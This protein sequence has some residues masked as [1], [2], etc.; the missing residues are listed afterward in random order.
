[1]HD[2][3]DHQI[4]TSPKSV[5]SNAWVAR[6][7]PLLAVLPNPSRCN[8]LVKLYFDKVEWIHH[9]I[10]V[11]SFYAWFRQFWTTGLTS[12]HCVQQLAL[13]FA[14]L[15]L[16]VHFDL[17]LEHSDRASLSLSD[18]LDAEDQCFY[19]ASYDALVASAYLGHHSLTVLQTL[20]LQGLYLNNSGQTA[21]HHANL[22]LAIR[23]AN[24]MGLS[25]LDS[26]LSQD[27]AGPSAQ[28]TPSDLLQAEMGRR[29]YWSLV[30][31]DSYT[32][33][34]CNF[35]YSVQPNQ[36]KTRI[37]SNLP[38]D[39]LNAAASEQQDAHPTFEQRPT[40]TATFE[41]RVEDL[42]SMLP[43]T[44]TY[45][46]AKIP[47]A[48]TARKTV[49][50]HNEGTL[51][52]A[53][54]LEL[55][56][57]NW[58]HFHALPDFL[59]LDKPRPD[60]EDRN[61][62]CRLGWGQPYPDDWQ[63]S[64]VL[65]QQI[66]WQRLFLS[67]TLHNRILRLHRSYLTRAYTNA[68]YQ[69]SRKSALTSARRLLHLMEQGRAMAFPGLKWW[70][71][72]VH[73][74]TAAVALCIDLHFHHLNPASFHDAGQD[75]ATDNDRLI[76]L[77]IDILQSASPRSRAAGRA[78][79][80]I[81]TLFEQAQ[82]RQPPVQA[83]LSANDRRS[84]TSQKRPRHDDLSFEA[85]RKSRRSTNSSPGIVKGTEAPNEE[86]ASAQRRTASYEAPA[87]DSF[88]H[89]LASD[90]ASLINGTDTLSVPVTAENTDVLTPDFLGEI[91]AFVS[92]D[93]DHAMWQ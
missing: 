29:L 46:I 43:T 85:A 47:F 70:V 19:Q 45:H 35:T 27:K 1:M 74:F 90:W 44:S 3:F 61:T 58:D 39:A 52:Y 63:S 89:W 72:L 10:H 42:S 83:P 33:S 25:S 2:R 12:R 24:T 8:A 38:D 64:R 30:C 71:V 86:A 59:R 62:P 4:L 40:S 50:M 92:T 53:A 16:A 34:S 93:N 13:L 73:I 56:Q 75:D 66:D 68:S 57:E 67:I 14:M 79:G 32:A 76:R 31:Q 21:T 77:A 55:E 91:Q 88:E 9:P 60:L 18:C 84:V 5:S 69:A 20:I 80:I 11:P 36:V 82:T 26:A 28:S 6:A 87:A 17:E 49:D 41:Q 65:Q 7:Q 23:M 54:V 78:L 37:F 15:C 22:G 51:T 81:T 48:L